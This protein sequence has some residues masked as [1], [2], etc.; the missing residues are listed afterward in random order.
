MSQGVPVGFAAVEVQSDVDAVEEE[1]SQPSAA[2]ASACVQKS[3]RKRRK[4]PVSD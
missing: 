4:K 2:V 1:G 3:R